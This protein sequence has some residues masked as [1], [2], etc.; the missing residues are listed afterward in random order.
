MRDLV[1]ALFIL[2]SM[3]FSFRKPFLGILMFS[4][5][6]YMRLQDLAWG[7]AQGQRWSMYLAVISVAGYMADPNRK[8]PVLNVRTALLG[9]MVLHVGVGL[10]FA[11]GPAKVDLAAYQEYVKIVG[12]AVFTT[13]VVRTKSHLRI[14]IWV[15]AMGLGFHGAKNGLMAA[16][17]MGNLY[18]SHGPGGMIKDNNDFALAV[19]MIIP[20][21]YYLAQSETNPVLVR[22]LKI[23]VPLC[24]LTVI[25]TRSRGGTLSLAFMGALMVWRSRNRLIG[26]ILGLFAVVVVVAM[27]PEEYKER[28]GTIQTYEEDG[29]AMGRI[30]AWKVAFRMIDAHPMFGV[31]FNRFAMNHLEFEP[32]PTL[33]QQSGHSALVAHNS[34]LQIWAESGTPAFL[35]YLA[36][37]AATFWDVWRVRWRAKKLYVDSWI[38][39]YCSMFEVS[40]ATFML[41]SIFLNRAA[42]DLVYHLFAVVVVFGI[43]ARRQMDEDQASSKLPGGGG[44]G[45]DDW[46]ESPVAAQQAPRFRRVALES[47]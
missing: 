7:F 4:L 41:G 10:F 20:W 37:M 14:L 31:G 47:R 42:F 18:I 44:D 29:S 43:V 23:M 35:I 25:S 9:L 2:G 16:V 12:I 13:A 26:I 34:Y 30:R 38:L 24:A 39:S 32:N 36:L 19:A 15:I 28:L 40:L 11:Q 8:L 27:A 3:P 33:G 45:S 17:K 22:I 6:A 5:L 1:V 21:I 46:L